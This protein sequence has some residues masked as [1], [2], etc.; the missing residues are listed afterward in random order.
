VWYDCR[1]LIDVIVAGVEARTTLHMVKTGVLPAV[2]AHQENVYRSIGA[3]FNTMT[4]VDM[5]A[6]V[7]VG[8][9]VDHRSLFV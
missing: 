9:W 4:S 2:W 6:Q 5:S 3:V 8:G 7:W 1:S